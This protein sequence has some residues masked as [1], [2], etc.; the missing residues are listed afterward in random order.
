MCAGAEC[1]V[2]GP[3]PPGL[4]ADHDLIG[5]LERLADGRPLYTSR[6]ERN[7]ALVEEMWPAD[8]CGEVS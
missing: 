5:H 1:P 4:W 7:A 2:C 6:H 8:E 3:P